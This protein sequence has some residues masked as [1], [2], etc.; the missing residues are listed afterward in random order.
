MIIDAY[1][2]LVVRFRGTTFERSSVS[3]KLRLLPPLTIIAQNLCKSDQS[4]QNLQYIITTLNIFFQFC[5]DASFATVSLTCKPTHLDSYRGNNVL[6]VLIK[7]LS[8]SQK[9]HNSLG[10]ETCI[11]IWREEGLSAFTVHIP[12]TSSDPAVVS[13][14]LYICVIC[15]RQTQ[16]RTVFFYILASAF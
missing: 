3:Q 5:S 6:K 1:L 9:M 7:Q 11:Y 16:Q 13:I 10:I 12:D 14:H 8:C 2:Q 4:L 15:M